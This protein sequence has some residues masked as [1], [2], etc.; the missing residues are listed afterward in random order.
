MA[1]RTADEAAE[2]RAALLAAA[3]E[4]VAQRRYLGLVEQ[5]FDLVAVERV[6]PARS[7]LVSR[8]P[9][10]NIFG[11]VVRGICGSPPEPVEYAHVETRPPF[12]AAADRY[13]S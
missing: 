6:E 13:P 4:L 11:C 7:L 12:V 1:R 3:R 9:G 2:T 10:R 8:G 5:V